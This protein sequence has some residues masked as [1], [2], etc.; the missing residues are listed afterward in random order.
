M[1]SVLI[2]YIY[3]PLPT[4]HRQAYLEKAIRTLL[5]H[6]C[7]PCTIV[8][9]IDNVGLHI[10]HSHA[11]PERSELV[12]GSRSRYQ[13]LD[14]DLAI[15]FRAQPKICNQSLGEVFTRRRHFLLTLIQMAIH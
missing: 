5:Y 7:N 11:V 2:L 9:I 6:I 13:C 3:I 14:G 8:T 4:S 1:S 10:P 12:W 15:A